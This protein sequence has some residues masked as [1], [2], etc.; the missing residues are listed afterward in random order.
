[1]IIAKTNVVGDCVLS[2]IC[3]SQTYVRTVQKLHVFEPTEIL[4]STTA[5]TPCK[6]KLVCIIEENIIGAKLIQVSKLPGP[7]T[8]I[9]ANLVTDTKKVL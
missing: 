5:I 2:E 4:I 8:P 9:A 7:L 1:M 6:S 3:D